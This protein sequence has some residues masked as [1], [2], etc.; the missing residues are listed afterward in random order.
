[1]G[2]WRSGFARD[3]IILA[4]V[5]ILV[6][7]LL[8]GAVA[9]AVDGY[10]QNTVSRLAGDYGEYDCLI[11]VRQETKAA[12]AETLQ[13]IVQKHLPGARFKEGVTVAGKVNY[14]FSIPKDKENEEVYENLR[15]W[16]QQVPGYAGLTYIIE[17]S[18]TA[19]N[20]HPG[21]RETLR[22][23]MTALPGVRF[24][25]ANG[26]NL[27]AVL[28]D[29]LK[30]EEA[31]D[32]LNRLVERYRLLEVRFPFGY[33]LSRPE[34]AA[35]EVEEALEHM[36]GAGKAK[37][38]TVAEQ[39]EEMN[40]FLTTLQEMKRF[41]LSYATQVEMELDQPGAVIAGD[42][43][44]LRP[45]ATGEGGGSGGET[46]DTERPV[47]ARV[48]AVAD[49]KATGI[50]EEGD[51]AQLIVAP[52]AGDNEAAESS[53]AQVQAPAQAA[54]PALVYSEDGR[55]LGR[56]EVKSERRQLMA[57]IDEGIELL[58]R[59]DVL[60]EEAEKAAAGAEETLKLFDAALLQLETL[61]EQVRQINEELTTKGNVN[62]GELLISALLTNLLRRVEPES[63]VTQL[64]DADIQGM[65]KQLRAMADQLTA[66]SEVDLQLIAEELKRIRQH[67]PD[68]SDGEIGESLHLIDR[69]L[70]GQVLPGDRLQL[71]IAP[72][73]DLEQ[74]AALIKGVLE[75]QGVSLFT[76]PAA[77]VSPDAR[78]TLFNV[79][80]QV[81]ATIAG[82]TAAALVILLFI[83]DQAVLFSTW[84]LLGWRTGWLAA[85][86]GALFL[87]AIYILCGAAIPGAGWPHV[88][89]VGAILGLVMYWLAP[90]LSPVN[91][92]EVEAG[93][94]LG[95][96]TAQVL[97]EIVIPAGRPGLLMLLN[98]RRMVFG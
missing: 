71:L 19:A 21:V 43:L 64:K 27:I 97:R 20:V 36:W 81:R 39:D 98:R 22:R 52:Q 49:R 74:S 6:C 31:Y 29:P 47:L 95:L 59:L 2:L 15:G 46:G 91:A 5:S 96:S 25:F 93:L 92:D 76:T 72:E 56:A 86:A 14:L 55:P 79:L 37:D 26:S 69:Y 16:L 70:D 50:I 12:A 54:V 18:V 66:I 34:Q 35:L 94:A 83:L 28:D 67:L 24:V 63:D 45:E 8:S 65:Q 3:Y 90:R 89:A 87:T 13:D 42:I 23:E 78:T 38:V 60:A 10:L 68:L 48:T 17:P 82:I 41:L 33:S 53:P 84:R 88:L 61:Q 51:V 1:M 32:K 57:A 30:A 11:Q 75:Y 4:I 80:G 58:G 7:S 44:T 62:T 40:S 73:V 85:G 9:L 77:T